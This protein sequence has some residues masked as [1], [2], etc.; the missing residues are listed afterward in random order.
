MCNF[1]PKRRKICCDIRK[2]TFSGSYLIFVLRVNNGTCFFTIFAVSLQIFSCA[3]GN[4]FRKTLYAQ[5]VD[6][7]TYFTRKV[8][9]INFFISCIYDYL[10]LLC[11]FIVLFRVFLFVLVIIRLI[12]FF[13]LLKILSSLHKQA[14]NLVVR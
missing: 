4:A 8:A 12:D 10:T 5:C 13:Y 11:K 1:H 9:R 14:L 6:I 7:H 3:N 2:L